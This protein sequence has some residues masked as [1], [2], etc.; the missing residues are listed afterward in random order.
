MRVGDENSAGIGISMKWIILSMNIT[1][2][3]IDSMLMG[4]IIILSSI[5]SLNLVIFCL[6]LCCSS[7]SYMFKCI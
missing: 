5:D 7:I 3:R 1:N 4:I 6:W 2:S